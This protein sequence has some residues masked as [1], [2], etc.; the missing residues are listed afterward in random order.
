MTSWSSTIYSH[1]GESMEAVTMDLITD[2]PKTNDGFNAIVVFVNCRTKMA[3]F[4]TVTKSHDAPVLAKVFMQHEFWL[5][6]IPKVIILDRD[7]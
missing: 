3:H 6:G 1:S 5:H 4:V 2:L 7:P